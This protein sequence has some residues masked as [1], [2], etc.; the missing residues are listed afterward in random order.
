MSEITKDAA[1][2]VSSA[3]VVP[4]TV[5]D[6]PAST[7]VFD[8]Q[9][10]VQETPQPPPMSPE[11][12][13]F[14]ALSLQEQLLPDRPE[15]LEP[16]REEPNNF[17]QGISDFSTLAII[18]RAVDEMVWRPSGSDIIDRKFLETKEVWEQSIDN[19]NDLA[20]ELKARGLSDPTS[21][22]A[23]ILYSYN[24]AGNAKEAEKWLL[25]FKRLKEVEQ[26]NEETGGLTYV[27]GGIVGFATDLVLLNWAAIPGKAATAMGGGARVAAAALPE[28]TLDAWARG[29]VD[30]TFQ[31]SDAMAQVLLG[32][33]AAW[34]LGSVMHKAQSRVTKGSAER[35][36]SNHLADTSGTPNKQST[37]AA[38][39]GEYLQVSPTEPAA[40]YGTNRVLR[41]ALEANGMRPI[42]FVRAPMEMVKDLK[43]KIWDNPTFHPLKSVIESL[44][45]VLWKTS[46]ITKPELSGVAPKETIAE[47]MKALKITMRAHV[48]D[49]DAVIDSFMKTH[50]KL[51]D[52]VRKNVAVAVGATG[53][54]SVP[55]HKEIKHL[56]DLVAQATDDAEKL[57]PRIDDLN[58][59]IASITDQLDNLGDDVM[60]GPSKASLLNKQDYYEEQLAKVLERKDKADLA[61][62]DIN[63]QLKSRG[64]E[65]GLESPDEFTALVSKISDMDSD[66]Y[67]S[68][69]E[70]MAKNGFLNPDEIRRGYRPQQIDSVVAAQNSNE[71]KARL[72][73]LFREEG[74]DEEFIAAWKER[75]VDDL[76]DEGIDTTNLQGKTLEEIIDEDPGLA[77]RLTEDYEAMIEEGM[78][79]QLDVAQRN[80]QYEFGKD[81]EDALQTF[82]STAEQRISKYTRVLEGQHTKLAELKDLRARGQ[83]TGKASDEKV[84]KLVGHI[85]KNEY[86]QSQ[87]Q[88]RL[89]DVN[90]LQ[91]H[92]DGLL[93]ALGKPKGSALEA[94]RVLS[95]QL[96]DVK[97]FSSTLS[98]GQLA[99]TTGFKLTNAERALKRSL[100]A[101]HRKTLRKVKGN[102]LTERV[103]ETV[104]NLTQGRAVAAFEPDDYIQ[105]SSRF[106]RRVIDLSGVRHR[107]EWQK[108]LIN[109]PEDTLVGYAESVGIQMELNEK[110]GG[111][112]RGA[113]YLK[114]GDYKIG[115]AWENWAVDEID[116]WIGTM[117]TPEELVEAQRMKKL[118][119]GM[120]KDDKGLL[121]K[122]IKQFTR[123]DRL[124]MFKTEWGA[125]ADRVLSVN[126]ALTSA[127]ILGRVM[128]Q[129]PT[130]L[131]TAMQGGPRWY[132]IFR[133]VARNLKDG[134]FAGRMDSLTQRNRKLAMTVR[135]EHIVSGDRLNSRFDTD[136]SPMFTGGTRGRRVQLV[137][138]NINA[139][140]NYANG[141]IPWN[142]MI[143][144]AAGVEVAGQ[145]LEDSGN[146][147]KLGKRL[148]T[149]YTHHG[150]GAD[151]MT[152]VNILRRNS[153]VID[154]KGWKLS[155]TNEWSNKV[156]GWNDAGEARIFNKGDDIPFE[157]STKQVDGSYIESKYLRTIENMADS[158]H[159]EPGIGERPFW[160]AS[161]WGR[162]MMML[163]S[164]TYTANTKFVAP[165]VQQV[166]LHNQEAAARAGGA[167]MMGL[168]LG[169]LGQGIRDIYDDRESA[170]TKLLRGE[171]LSNEEI[172]EVIRV[173]FR[174]SPMNVGMLDR[175]YE[176]FSVMTGESI[177]N[178]VGFDIMDEVPLKNKNNADPWAAF[179]GPTPGNA[180][181]VYNN[182]RAGDVE[183]LSKSIPIWNS[184]LTQTMMKY[185]ID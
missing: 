70:R 96:A 167:I 65:I 81:L 106:K 66:F 155:D 107:P 164:F 43:V 33:G 136:N 174:R 84:N 183:A 48:A 41:S 113:G 13:K 180:S 80:I 156:I 74:P 72:W 23:Q 9:P 32:A 52:R 76:A 145:V 181:R 2:D 94:E 7:V 71:L 139:V 16:L 39:A 54:K 160:S 171:S 58:T 97:D 165:M 166:A 154:E 162:V 110:M 170:F 147:S 146:W 38:S 82:A 18:G 91:A 8:G 36:I 123:A 34:G 75:Y 27:M 122:A 12:H 24:V 99:S 140:S 182:L 22:A 90:Q 73:D 93:D 158:M 28:V 26:I 35:T 20:K 134:D 176:S 169:A 116:R 57:V 117:K 100:A 148:Q 19:R 83:F 137:A 135:G 150:L 131:A 61:L 37:G 21:P 5:V 53:P 31:K 1:I 111:F 55:S 46:G 130:D 118:L 133:G 85:N 124:D 126:S 102:L 77:R 143:R 3:T 47:G 10:A 142:R 29:E 101:A 109:D 17:L 179:M 115:D 68:M 151:D 4:T 185:S 30:P 104:R 64:S 78:Y 175:M 108:F 120:G 178:I 103:D 129:L 152:A 119:V 161:P 88:R 67:L 177:N 42:D 44:D 49:T 89:D 50:Y 87:W 6:S 184:L 69:S 105:T 125:P 149:D 14:K 173:A 114:D 127:M 15:P 157:W 60:E 132:S 62:E 51:M 11:L 79:E 40:A 138:Q 163:T 128:F 144:S 112:L 98:R 45:G 59:K 95:K 121:Q 25:R 159:L 86:H 168:A 172:A 141:M 56:G 92:E 63:A 153:S